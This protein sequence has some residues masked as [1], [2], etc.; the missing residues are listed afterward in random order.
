MN[1]TAI[2][3]ERAFETLTGF[4]PMKWQE[5]LF[6]EHFGA[7]K[8]PDAVDIPTGLGKTSVMA[9]WYLALREGVNL[10][11]RLVYVVDRRAVVDQAT[12][13]AEKIKERSTDERLCISTLRGQHLDNRDW[14]KDPSAPAIIVGTVDMI[15]SRLLFSGYGVSRKVRPYHAGLLG[16]DTLVVLDEA[17]LVPAFEKL[18]IAIED[19][20]KLLGP[21][22]EEARAIVPPFKL[23]S[24]SATGRE[25]QGTV[26]CLERRDIEGDVIVQE[27][28]HAKKHLRQ[29]GLEQES[30]KRPPR[31]IGDND[32]T[33][34]TIEETLARE[35]WE[36]SGRGTRPLRILIYCDRRE[37]AEKTKKALSKK[38]DK[39]TS[40][41]CNSD[42][43]SIELFVGA[44]RV[45]E[46]ADA[47]AQLKELGF[48]AGSKVHLGKPV[49]L[50]ATSAGEVGVDL[51]A[52]HMVC[53]LVPWDRMVQ[54]LG[55]V[56]RLGKGDAQ[57]VMV[58]EPPPTP[59][60]KEKEALQKVNGSGAALED[61]ERKLI[62]AFRQ[63]V[64]EWQSLQEPIK[65][66]RTD[67]VG[68]DVSPGAL[69]ELKLRAATDSK[70]EEK[71]RAAT[72]PLPLYPALTRPLVEAWSLTSLKE[73]PGRPE[74]GPWLRGWVEDKSQTAVVWRRFL[75]VRNDG[76]PATDKEVE[77]FFETAPPHLSEQLETESRR[78]AAWLTKRAQKSKPGNFDGPVAFVLDPDGSLR[79]SV[80]LGDL[81]PH[82]EEKGKDSEDRIT[83]AISGSTVVVDS[84]LAGLKD[85]L[86]DEDCD[87]VPRTID[88]GEDWPCEPGFRVLQ[89]KA[90]EDLSP[91]SMNSAKITFAFTNRRSSEG[92][93]IEQLL[94][95]SNATEESKAASIHPQLLN[96]HRRWVEDEVRRIAQALRIP[97]EGER[98][99]ALASLLHDEGKTSRRWQRAFTA[100]PGGPYAKTRGPVLNA[101]LG[102]YRHEVGSLILA[103][104]NT[105]LAGLADEWRDLALHLIAAHHGSGRPGIDTKGCDQSPPSLLKTHAQEA[106][107][108]FARLQHRWGPW[109]LAWWEALLRAAD[110]QASRRN[111]QEGGEA[112]G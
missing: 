54:R 112:H 86:L 90:A 31:E 111:D 9:I 94:I 98:T 6:S 69:R 101:I 103:Q 42:S 72:T 66:L 82:E 55:R 89:L 71:I 17:H 50:V 37:V 73:H 92:E 61:K 36:L 99:L 21:Q 48:L 45:K 97:E 16:V 56:N 25:R 46:R 110:Q 38:E 59:S 14:L 23:L 26:F 32:D 96:D 11:R 79:L 102:G 68:V 5:R 76:E 109:G 88:D 84:R 70:V 93:A 34:T 57:V 10:P 43:C 64:A 104:N 39:S 13:E 22:E 30:E 4:P 60:K 67:G 52:D 49:F 20:K 91:G 80:L 1:D 74:V 81:R 106:P 107:L 41:K 15:G 12:A 2:S 51:D 58:V 87:E 105:A 28:L 62:E 95:E 8:L 75:P 7:G 19:G 100:P 40:R 47:E 77:T 108:R 65:L 83:S 44:R 29:P 18:L 3:F 78:I 53:D 24:L 35:A 27:R 33:E 63:K 85:G